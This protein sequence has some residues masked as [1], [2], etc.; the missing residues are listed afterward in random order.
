KYNSAGKKGCHAIKYH[1]VIL[2]HKKVLH[3]LFYLPVFIPLVKY[4]NTLAQCHL[5]DGVAAKKK[6]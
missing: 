4:D 1:F 5:F 3:Y 6:T 2:I